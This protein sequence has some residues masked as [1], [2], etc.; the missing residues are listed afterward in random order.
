MTQS[1]SLLEPLP[2]VSTLHRWL[3]ASYFVGPL[4]LC[5]LPRTVTPLNSSTFPT[6]FSYSHKSSPRLC[7]ALRCILLFPTNHWQHILRPNRPHGSR[8]TVVLEYVSIDCAIV[9]IRTNDFTSLM[10]SPPVLLIGAAAATHVPRYLKR[11]SRVCISIGL[12]DTAITQTCLGI[13]L[14]LDKPFNRDTLKRFSSF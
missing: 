8:V 7:T 4:L 10:D 6:L 13:L 12:V 1:L 14:H 11:L 2:E 9:I 5:F 3:M